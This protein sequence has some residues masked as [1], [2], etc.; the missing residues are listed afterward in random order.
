MSK[1]WVGIVLLLSVAS[2]GILLKAVATQH[3]RAHDTTEPV[4]TD[5]ASAEAGMAPLE[6]PAAPDGAAASGATPT[7]NSVKFDANEERVLRM[8]QPAEKRQPVEQAR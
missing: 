4:Q 7:G 2:V 8:R 5:A 1:L 3:L 6:R